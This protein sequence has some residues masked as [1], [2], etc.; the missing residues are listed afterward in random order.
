MADSAFLIVSCGR[1]KSEMICCA[2]D[3]YNSSRFQGLKSFAEVNH[4]HWGIFSA[5]Y[6]L[7]CPEEIIEPYDVNLNL[8][9]EEQR[10]KLRDLF[11]K[12]LT[13]F[14]KTL[15][16]IIIADAM[17]S[18]FIAPLLQKNGFSLS[19]PFLNKNDLEVEEYIKKAKYTNHVLRFYNKLRY[20]AEATGG[21]RRIRDC[22]GK[23]Y[24][25]KKGVYFI[26][27]NNE[28]TLL[29][30]GFPRVVRVG[31]HAVS[32]GSKSTLWNRLKTHKGSNNGE[33]N[34]RGSIF[35]LHVGNSLIER[36]NLFI[37]SWGH[38][39]TASKE[40][41]QSEGPLERMVSDYIGELG[42]VVLDVD[43]LPSSTSMRAYIEKNAIALL[44]SLNSS[45][46]FAAIDWLGNQNPRSEIRDSS[47]WNINYINSEYDP[48]FI[49]V[50][51]HFVDET[52]AHYN[53]RSN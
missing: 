18:E 6:A 32:K 20:L 34:H 29:G 41:R 50:F 47:L 51:S 45:F 14:P 44:S 27:D 7:L 40:T 49:D 53:N 46:N 52:I 33:G 21:V 5:K 37:S 22:T 12:Q 19:A 11:E 13:V 38:G 8:C 25:P 30:K 16:F 23:Q 42:V 4:L 36:N 26:L 39:Q 48:I 3:M 28:C 1:R 43:D 17:Y 2:K 9:T 15:E 10:M 35:R 24:W 31:T